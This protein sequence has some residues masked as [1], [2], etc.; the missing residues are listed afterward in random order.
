MTN[1][2]S[3]PVVGGSYNI[4]E[5]VAAERGKSQKQEE[6][7][8]I[9]AARR[10][11]ELEAARNEYFE[12]GKN[13]AA[14]EFDQLSVKIKSESY[15]EGFQKGKDEASKELE[16]K[17]LALKAIFDQWNED[18]EKFLVE[19]ES[20]AVELVLAIEKKIVGYEIQKSSEPLKHV[21]REAMK[22]IH[23]KKDLRIRVSSEDV[24]FFKQG[25][26]D[27]LKTFG[28]NIEVIDDADLQQ[29]DCVVETCI[30]SVD[31]SVETRWNMIVNKFFTGIER[32]DNDIFKDMPAETGESE[33]VEVRGESDQDSG[34]VS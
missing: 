28:E 10:E 25:T 18:K 14:A 27:F 20:D 13:E 6:E 19:L 2:L 24:E 3:K 8:A 7:E 11:V 15:E 23:D 1:I 21:I 31:A 4:N 22:M 12:K 17:Y 30:G 9:V 33:S 29:G 26:D 5:I 16:P 34:P 32:G